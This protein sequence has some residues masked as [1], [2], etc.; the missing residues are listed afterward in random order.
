MKMLTLLCSILLCISAAFAQSGTDTTSSSADNRTQFEGCL[1]GSDGA[2]TLTDHSGHE[3]KLTGQTAN[4]E[5]MVNQEI[6]VKGEKQSSSAQAST[7]SSSGSSMSS[8]SSGDAG[9][10]QVSSVTALDTSCRM[11]KKVQH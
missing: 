2:F 7:S 8:S 4:L 5:K 11:G 9:T 1:H 10:I 3:Y 6:Q